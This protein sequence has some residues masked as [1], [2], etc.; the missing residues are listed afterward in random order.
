MWGVVQKTKTSILNVFVREKLL[1]E[2]SKMV[3]L[4]KLLSIET[5]YKE[6]IFLRWSS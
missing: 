4:P 1:P 6:N 2:W 3:W 5:N